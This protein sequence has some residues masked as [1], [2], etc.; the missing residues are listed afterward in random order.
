MAFDHGSKAYLGVDDSGDTLRD[1]SAYLTSTGL[2]Q[3]ADTAEVSTLGNTSKSYVPGLKDATIPLE[4]PWDPTVD[5]YLSGILATERD[6]EYGPQ[7]NTGGYVKYSG[8]AILT[9][10]EVG[11]GVDDAG[12][13][14]AELQVTDGVTRGTF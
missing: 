2:P 14:S 13:F 7:G 5:G 8:R 10:Y 6:F 12:T 3:S 9:S 11:T 4:G 1:L